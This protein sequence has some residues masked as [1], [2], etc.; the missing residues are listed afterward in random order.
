MFHWKHPAV[1]PFDWIFR[2]DDNI[3]FHCVLVS[4]KCVWL[5]LNSS[6]TLPQQED[7][8]L[9]VSVAVQYAIRQ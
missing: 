4:S 9:T 5:Q 2:L 6:S 7:P 1:A 3:T 8:F